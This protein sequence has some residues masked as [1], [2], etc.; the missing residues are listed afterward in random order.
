MEAKNNKRR[1][2][3]GAVVLVILALI[4][5]LILRQNTNSRNIIL[6]DSQES[7]ISDDIELYEVESSPSVCDGSNGYIKGKIQTKTHY[8]Q[9]L[10]VFEVK[11]SKNNVLYEKESYFASGDNSFDISFIPKDYNSEEYIFVVHYKSNAV[12]TK[13]FS[14]IKESPQ[15]EI[16]TSYEKKY[17]ESQPRGRLVYYVIEMSIKPKT[18]CSISGITLT[19]MALFDKT[20][21]RVRIATIGGSDYEKMTIKKLDGMQVWKKITCVVEKESAVNYNHYDYELTYGVS[22]DFA[23]NELCYVKISEPN[24]ILLKFKVQGSGINE[25]T[26]TLRVEI[27]EIGFPVE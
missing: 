4:V 14:M 16:K 24:N 17:V 1:I 20:G 8:D 9:N 11:D 21:E 26:N 2:M 10:V 27:P 7:A 6:A 23:M 22:S 25:S 15:L 13:R 12:Y 5:V 19:P 18:T 3:I